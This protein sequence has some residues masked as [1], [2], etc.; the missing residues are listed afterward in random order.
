MLVSY[1][2]L[3]EFAGFVFLCAGTV[4]DWRIGRSKPELVHGDE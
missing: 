2:Q 1:N 3:I 4:M